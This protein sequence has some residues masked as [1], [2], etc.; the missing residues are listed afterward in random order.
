MSDH[1]GRVLACKLPKMAEFH[2]PKMKH[3][4]VVQRVPEE[5]PIQS[6][7]V[8]PVCPY[9]VF[10]D[11]MSHDSSHCGEFSALPHK[12]QSQEQG[13]KVLNKYTGGVVV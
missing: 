9:R 5:S 11:L 12:K 8:A 3:L 4:E 7:W 13:F 6:Q 1:D 10:W 2:D